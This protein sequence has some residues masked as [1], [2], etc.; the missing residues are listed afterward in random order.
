MITA[1]I[2][3]IEAKIYAEDAHIFMRGNKSDPLLFQN[4]LLKQSKNFFLLLFVCVMHRMEKVEKFQ[5]F[6]DV[7]PFDPK[8]N[9]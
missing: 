7:L 6:G 4:I 2:Y 9:T 8:E 3:E 5:R 1:S